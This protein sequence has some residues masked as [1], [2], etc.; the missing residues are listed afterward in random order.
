MEHYDEV[1]TCNAG[2]SANVDFGEWYAPTVAVSSVR[3][4]AALTCKRNLDLCHFHI[5]QDVVQ[6]DLE[7]DVYLLLPQG[8]GR[9]SGKIVR[10]NLSLIHI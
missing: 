7:E 5:E 9:L 3:L 2:G 10:L 6:S 8:G 1:N 4:L